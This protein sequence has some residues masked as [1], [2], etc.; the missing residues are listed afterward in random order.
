MAQ[1]R[2]AILAFGVV[3]V[4]APA[5]RADDARAVVDKAIKAHGGADAISKFLGHTVQVKGTFHG[6]GQEIPF[7]GTITS[8]GR[9]RLKVELEVEAGG[10]KFRIVNVVTPDK[11][12]ARFDKDTREL[13]KEELAEAHERGHAGWV[14]TLAPLQDKSVT[15]ATIGEV[16]IDKK[17]AIGVKV[18][19]KGHRDVDLYFDK[20]TGLLVKSETL[21]KD[22]GSGQE[23]TTETFY[24]DYKDV[25]GTKQAMKL[26]IK[27]DGKLYLDIDVTDYQL[28][29]KLD[30]GVFAKP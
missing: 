16:E 13:D 23:V 2:Y 26:V 5:A 14:A 30:D 29:E 3:A 27:R 10:Q 22:E 4:A 15:L 6:M 9:D 17:P 28:S 19:M 24:S 20:Q 11:G 1:I 21:V 18:S 8:Q 7:N 25:Q 12:W